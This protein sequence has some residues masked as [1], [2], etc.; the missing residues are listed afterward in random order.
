MGKIPGLEPCEDSR[1]CLCSSPSGPVHL[2]ALERAGSFW[3]RE[4]LEYVA[5]KPALELPHPLWGPGLA[6]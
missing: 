3:R 4:G 2:L 6:V 1:A 5:P